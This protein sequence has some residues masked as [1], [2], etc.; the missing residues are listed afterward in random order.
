MRKGNNAV[1]CFHGVNENPMIVVI[2][3]DNY[4]GTAY[5]TETSNWLTTIVI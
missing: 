5:P 2:T 1:K 4:R 3:S